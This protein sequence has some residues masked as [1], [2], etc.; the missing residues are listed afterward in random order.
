MSQ[1]AIFSGMYEELRDYAELL[2]KTLVELK[3]QNYLPQDERRQQ[4]GQFLREL[5]AAQ[6]RSLAVRLLG[7]LLRREGTVA[8]QELAR[9][10]G[11]LAGQ[12]AIR[13]DPGMISQLEKLARSLAQEQATALARMRGKDL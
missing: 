12:E 11:R 9:I 3:S 2:D 10:G 8:P 7:R 4:L 5:G 13:I 6:S 1:T